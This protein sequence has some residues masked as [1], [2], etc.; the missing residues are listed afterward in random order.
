MK[1]VPICRF[2][3][4]KFPSDQT[5]FILGVNKDLDK[6]ILEAR[7]KD[8]NK[9]MKYLLRQTYSETNLEESEHWKVLKQMSF[10]EFIHQAGMFNK[11]KSLSS[12]S[13]EEIEDA[14]SRYFNAISTNIKGT[15]MVLLKRN[16]E[17]IFIN[18][19][20]QKI[21]KL[22]LANHDLQIV[23]DQYA[24]AQYVCGYLTKNEGGISKLLKAVNDECGNEGQ[25]QK[26]NKLAAVLDKHREVSVQEAVYR[27]LSL[28]M[29][30]SS[31][32]VK[33]I[34]TI[35]PHHRDGLLKGNLENIDE[36][37]SIFHNSIHQYYEN[38][39]EKSDEQNVLY[40]E[41]EK[42]EDYW[43]NLSLAE[44]VSK[45]EIVYGKCVKKETDKNRV[46]TLLNG[47]G[48]IRRR[49]EDAVLRYYL[50][51]DNDEDLARGLLILFMPFRDE[52]TEI[53]QLEV[54][55]LLHE[56]KDL[57]KE[58]RKKFE[59]Y[60]FMSDLIDLIQK[61]NEKNVD[62]V[63][64][65]EENVDE[66]TT[67]HEDIEEFNTWAKN[68]A[69]NE[70]S[71]FKDLIDLL[72]IVELRQRISELNN[73]QRRIFD[74]F[75]ERIVSKDINEPPVYLFITGNAG[76]GKSH[77]VKL[78]IEAVKIIKITPGNDIK[79][80]PLLTMAPTAN[81]AFIIGGRTIDSCLG[82][83]PMDCNRYIQPNPGRLS[84]MKFQYEDAGVMFIDEISM[85]GSMKLT[86]IHFRLQDLADGNNKL[87]F[88]GG[89]SL[90]VLGNLFRI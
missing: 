28:P 43:L 41:E 52:M 78:L 50:S 40:D 70:L 58:K 5:K 82:F 47:K 76:T 56:K 19:Y 29:T 17:H 62:V 75:C 9:I 71:K 14:R 63:T 4:P 80:P 18:G 21:M 85:V 16:V 33:Y 7:R 37:D 59:K 83:T 79:K 89:R 22:H 60:H 68:Q 39:P 81:A 1:N 64:D 32:K 27:L 87:K 77:L 90:V 72:D 34:S 49:F 57:I 26:L 73:Q 23:I 25:I 35:H 38:R 31:V 12:Y 53:H 55:K 11:R 65:D 88:M 24:A 74:D 2:N 86:K 20:N 48:Y 13:N 36:D 45:Y 6:D 3:F 66:E 67:A 69:T 8:F 61:G 84:M 30:K 51:Y 15:G 54:E 44:F 46:Q 10:L 42:E